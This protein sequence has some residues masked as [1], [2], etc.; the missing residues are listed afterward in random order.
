MDQPILRV[1]N[2]HKYFY[3]GRNLTVH[4]V[5]GIDF[6]L[7]REESGGLV[8]ES[9]CGKTTTPRCIVWLE[10]ATMGNIHLHGKQK[11]AR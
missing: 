1:E 7:G 6:E 11:K 2:L 4:A 8:G 9:G 5:N 10:K 3:P